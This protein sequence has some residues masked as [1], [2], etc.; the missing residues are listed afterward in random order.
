RN[1]REIVADI[2]YLASVAIEQHRVNEELER[3]KRQLEEHS[4]KL[5]E[6][7]K[8]RTDELQITVQKLV[9][10]NLSLEGQILETKAAGGRAL[11]SQ[12]MFTA[13]SRNFPKGAIIVFNADFEIVYIDGGELYR[14]GF[15][16]SQFEGLYIDDL[17]IFS[18]QRIARIKEDIKRTIQGETLS[19]EMKFRNKSYSVNTSPLLGG[20]DQVKWTLF[21]YNDITEQKEA[22]A[23]I[24]R[25]LIQEQELNE[26]KSRFISM[27]SH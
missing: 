20:N 12:A 19:F 17:D 11:E 1:E 18:K 23:K 10:T 14:M 16:K 5:E 25:A 9:E 8:E 26:L 15:N 22:E 4:Q 24:R 27:A 13:I 6:K 2:T 21:V 3:S 7:I